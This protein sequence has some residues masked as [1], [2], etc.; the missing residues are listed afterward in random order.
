MRSAFDSPNLHSTDRALPE[1]FGGTQGRPPDFK[2]L[3][4]CV[5]YPL[6]RGIPDAPT[7]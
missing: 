4:S 7:V 1:E 2:Y 5:C 6:K 3:R